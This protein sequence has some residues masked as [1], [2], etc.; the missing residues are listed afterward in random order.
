[1][2]FIRLILGTL[3]FILILMTIIFKKIHNTNNKIYDIRDIII[4]I[5]LIIFSYNFQYFYIGG[6]LIGI[7]CILSIYYIS[8]Q[9]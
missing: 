9:T 4:G 1:M 6:I 8:K 2:N 3:G 7:T 5:T